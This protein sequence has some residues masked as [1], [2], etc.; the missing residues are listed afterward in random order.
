MEEKTYVGI[1][2]FT[3]YDA[4]IKNFISGKK[5]VGTHEQ[6]ETAYAN[7]EIPVNTLVIFTDDES[8]SSIS[9]I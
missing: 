4:L 6:Y 2:G 1:D 8:S 3:L 5:F 7:G 9:T